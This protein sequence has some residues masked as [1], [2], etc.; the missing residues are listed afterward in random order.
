[1]IDIR[2]DG[3]AVFLAVKVVP[4]A[5][6]TRYAGQWQSRARIAVAAPPE[7]GRANR[8]VIAFISRLLGVRPRDVSI[9][10]GGTSPQ[11][12]IRIEG[13]TADAVRRALGA[14]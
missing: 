5:S 7:M 10:T 4:G 14:E 13:V 3:N 6:R 1:M 9:V 8:A 12:T 11:K 2:A